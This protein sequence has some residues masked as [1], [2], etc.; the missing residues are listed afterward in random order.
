MSQL[1]IYCVTNNTTELAD[2][3]GVGVDTGETVEQLRKGGAEFWLV[4][5][6]DAIKL[7]CYGDE[8]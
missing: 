5:L 1:A 3:N 7:S 4:S 2:E 6:D 8:S